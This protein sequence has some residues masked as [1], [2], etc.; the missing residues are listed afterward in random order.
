[1]VSDYSATLKLG[2]FSA[3][4]AAYYYF[5]IIVIAA[6]AD[7]A[8][9]CSTITLFISRLQPVRFILSIEFFN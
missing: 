8:M 7:N 1:M 4:S 6:A 2:V 3:S 9:Q 5:G